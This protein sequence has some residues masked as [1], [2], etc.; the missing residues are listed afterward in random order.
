MKKIYFYLL[1]ALTFLCLFCTWIK[2][3]DK[4]Y[5]NVII[6]TEIK[7]KDDV[8][9]KTDN[10]Y[11]IPPQFNNVLNQTIDKKINSLE[12]LVDKKYK[13]KIKSF[14]IFNNITMYHF[15]DFTTFE[16]T[17]DKL[18]SNN[19][20]K[21]YNKYKIKKEIIKPHKNKLYSF[22]NSLARFDKIFY[23]FFILVFL[24]VLYGYKLKINKFVLPFCIL[25]LA[26]ILRLSDINSYLPWGDECFSI[27][28]SKTNLP[29]LS[30][31]NDPGNPPFYFFL[32]KIIQYFTDSVVCFR[33]LNV[34]FS[35]LGGVFLYLF[36]YK[37][38]SNKLATTALFLYAINLPLIYFSQEIR[39]YS[40]QVLLAILILI[41]INKILENSNIKN[42]I[43]YGILTVIAANTHYYQI[44]FI[45]TNFLYL[46]FNF[47]KN[48][49]KKD[50]IWL[51]VVNFIALLSFLPFYLMTA[52]TKA[53]LDV[54]FNTYIQPI[55]LDLI[56]KCIYFIFGG[57]IPLF[58]T[59]IFLFNKINFSKQNKT[60]IYCAW[61]I[62]S[63]ILAGIILSSTIRPMFV[64]HYL[65]FLIPFVIIILSFIYTFKYKNKWIILFFIFPIFFAQNYSK[66]SYTHFRKNNSQSYNV[67]KLAQKYKNKTGK[68]VMLILKASDKPTLN[69]NNINNFKIQTLNHLNSYKISYD[70]IKNIQKNNKNLTIFT[71]LFDFKNNANDLNN[72]TCYYNTTL[73]LCIWKIE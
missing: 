58:I 26:I 44:I 66:N 5:I 14:V 4:N 64:K 32:L 1:L 59:I 28:I 36:L 45:F 48:K 60:L 69:L 73:D 18:C 19:N 41:S 23:P 10:E 9:L 15:D 33:F 27:S 47:I 46:I 61:T 71:L 56:K 50:L 35:I 40:L 24:S 43:L 54:S 30:I 12:V 62:I 2:F 49:R 39:C 51:F 25:F 17:Q 13:N 72:Y 57:C 34:L 67:F 63:V 31:F 22:L 3:E 38:Y 29:F 65:L 16:K 53:L 42:W 55:S 6:E 37:N 21:I 52:H 20:C 11:F 8:L 7:N 70:E 68:E